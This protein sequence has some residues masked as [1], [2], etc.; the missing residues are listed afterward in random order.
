[1]MNLSAG[2]SQLRQC[3]D[4]IDGT[5]TLEMLLPELHRINHLLLEQLK[6]YASAYQIDVTNTQC[7]RL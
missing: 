3:L 6:Q 4:K 2:V 1:M 5:T 7:I